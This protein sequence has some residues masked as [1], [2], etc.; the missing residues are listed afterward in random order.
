M[1]LLGPSW[2]R[3]R[4][5][6]QIIKSSDMIPGALISSLET[7]KSFPIPTECLFVTA[8]KRTKGRSI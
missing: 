8:P 4:S 3:S 2:N 6:L 1:T 7:G 5:Q